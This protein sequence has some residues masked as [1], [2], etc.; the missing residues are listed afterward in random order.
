MV[1]THPGLMTLHRGTG[2]PLACSVV[3]RGAWEAGGAAGAWPTGWHSLGALEP[4][5]L[6]FSPSRTRICCDRVRYTSLSL[7]SSLRSSFSQANGQKFPAA[8]MAFLGMCGSAPSP[9]LHLMHT[10]V[11]SSPLFTYTASPTKHSAH[12]TTTALYAT[13]LTT[14]TTTVSMFAR[15]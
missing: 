13:V 4:W 14:P 2:W 9:S 1:I 11:L 12:A 3:E 10:S 6:R 8:A 15:P 7:R 5:C